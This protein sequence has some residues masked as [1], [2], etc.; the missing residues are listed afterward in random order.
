MSIETVIAQAQE[1]MKDREIAG[2]LLYDYRGLNPIFW[3]TVGPISNVTRPCWLWIPAD[4]DPQLLVSFV[5]QGRFTHLG[6][7]T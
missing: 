1:Y 4:G 3:D 5:D 6:I 2:W 7:E